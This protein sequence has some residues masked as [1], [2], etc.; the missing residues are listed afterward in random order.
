MPPD[1]KPSAPINEKLALSILALVQF[2]HIMDFMIMM[3]LGSHLMRVFSVTP[4]QFSYLVAA[5]GLSAGVFGF[6]GGFVLDRFERKHAL[7]TLYAGFILATLGCAL[8]PSYSILLFARVC[9]GACGGV[10]GS[11]VSAMVGDMVPP[12]RRGR[13]MGVVMSAFPLASVAGVPCGLWLVGRYEWHA[14]FF[15]LSAISLLIFIL[16]A[17]VLPHVQSH[18]TTAHPWVQM[19]AILT[20]RIHWRGFMLSAVLVFAGGCVIPFMAPSIVANVGLPEEKL[21]KIYLCGGAA[22]FF[23]TFIIGRLSDRYDK[24]YVLT[25]VTVIAAANVLVVTRLQPGP[26]II[27][28]TTTSMLFVTMSGRFAPTMAMIANA[29][30]ARYRGGFM[31]VN[32]AIQQ[33]ASGLAN[34]AAGLLVT[35]DSTGHLHGYPNAGYLSLCAFIGTVLLAWWLRSAAPHAALPSRLIRLAPAEA[36][37]ALPES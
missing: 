33:L 36:V 24:L 14:A 19:R 25:F 34:I 17:R 12:E 31:S 2:T 21:F 16:A 26:L 3:P 35:V 32:S 29:V 5:Y 10:A 28:L 4:G 27:T 7:L 11:V 9:A 15:L 22:T 23:S 37:V 20:H 1:T 6:A 30:E 13:A 18:L 8:A